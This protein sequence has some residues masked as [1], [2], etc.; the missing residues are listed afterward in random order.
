MT[1]KIAASVRFWFLGFGT[2]RW[3]LALGHS[4]ALADLFGAEKSC[5]FRHDQTRADG[6][7][8]TNGCQT[9]PSL[10]G[11]VP[12]TSKQR[13]SLGSAAGFVNLIAR[14]TALPAT[15][16][17]RANCRLNNRRHMPVV[18]T[19][20]SFFAPGRS[21]HAAIQQ[22]QDG[23]HALTDLMGGIRDNLDRQDRRQ[24]ELM[25]YL[26]SLP[27]V[28]EQLP[29]S[30]RVQG[31]GCR[32]SISSSPRKTRSNRSWPT[33]SSASAKP[34]ASRTRAHRRPRRTRVD[35]AKH[36]DETIAAHLQSVG[37]AMQN[38]AGLHPTAPTSCKT[39][40]TTSTL[41]MA[42]SNASCTSRTCAS[43]RCL[44]SRSFCRSAPAAVCI[45]G[46]LLLIKK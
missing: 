43:Q 24:A 44:Q 41:A 30:S 45:V 12:W 35:S 19:R 25:Q 39:S 10:Q 23:F 37:E 7:V 36:N 20:S 27:Q 13:F 22:L 2:F 9:G 32:R 34:A 28:L 18:V 3:S 17:T 38:A 6:R 11:R 31:E 16:P 15:A 42:S 26:S 5:L 46:Y 8:A 1:K 14:V 21:A 4:R 33:S 29:E 40:A